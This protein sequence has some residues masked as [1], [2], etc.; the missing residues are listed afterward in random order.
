MG[1]RLLFEISL[2]TVD[3]IRNGV[4][5]LAPGQRRRSNL[6]TFKESTPDWDGEKQQLVVISVA[7][8]DAMGGDHDDEFFLDFN[9]VDLPS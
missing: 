1:S 9:D 6:Y 5:T 3:F 8:K 7:C 4:D 2:E